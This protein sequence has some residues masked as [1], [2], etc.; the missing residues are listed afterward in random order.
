MRY[1]GR[2]AE[3]KHRVEELAEAVRSDREALINRE[4]TSISQ[5]ANSILATFNER[6]A[7]LREEVDLMPKPVSARQ[8]R[9]YLSEKD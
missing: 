1:G 2:E 8:L 9:R 4:F 6:L 5:A 7:V 3:Y